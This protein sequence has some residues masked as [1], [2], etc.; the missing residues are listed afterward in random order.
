MV[1]V[2]LSIKLLL[3]TSLQLLCRIRIMN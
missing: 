3:D 2:G 1:Y